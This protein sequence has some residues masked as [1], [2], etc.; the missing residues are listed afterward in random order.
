MKLVVI[1]HRL[2]EIGFINNEI[3]D[4]ISEIAWR[5]EPRHISLF[6]LNNSHRINRAIIEWM[7]K[8]YRL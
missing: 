5:V 7:I 6:Y 3:V 2:N 8:I 4:E 1:E